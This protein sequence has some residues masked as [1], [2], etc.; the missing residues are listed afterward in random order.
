MYRPIKP[1]D[2]SL[3]ALL[4]MESLPPG[5]SRQAF[6]ELLIQPGVEGYLFEEKAFILCRVVADEAEIL[7]FAVA[8]EV[9][10][11]GIGKTLLMHVN[12][13]LKNQ[14]VRALFLE[15]ATDN[16]AA[17]GLYKAVGFEE[18]GLRVGYYASANGP[19]DALVMRL[20]LT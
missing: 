11:Q 4:H 2:A 5:W 7:T 12:N 18:A 9:R 10:R 8:H 17:I 20:N 13:M 1:T 19:K 15:V 14:G 6:A 3:L 16:L